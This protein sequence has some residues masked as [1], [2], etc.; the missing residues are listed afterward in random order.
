MKKILLP[1]IAASA[2]VYFSCSQPKTP[3]KQS[4]REQLEDIRS[5]G[6][7]IEDPIEPDIIPPSIVKQSNLVKAVESAYKMHKKDPDNQKKYNYLVRM[8]KENLESPLFDISVRS[9]F[10][11]HESWK[12]REMIA[13][14]ERTPISVLA[15]GAGDTALSVN[16]AIWLRLV[17]LPN[18]T[19]MSSVV[20]EKFANCGNWLIQ[21]RLLEFDNTDFSNFV[22]LCGIY[23]FDSL[24]SKRVEME[25]SIDLKNQW[26]LARYG[27]PH[28]RGTIASRRDADPLVIAF[29]LEDKEYDVRKKAKKTYDYQK[30]ISPVK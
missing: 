30:S 19:K 24:I 3:E 4:F 21:E 16:R 17:A 18:D 13:A 27:S 7:S 10:M 8:V 20:Q 2:F 26:R 22:N 29:L 11:G 14:D 5:P 25:S 23:R 12:I 9:Y 28:V 1:I 15:D 6:A